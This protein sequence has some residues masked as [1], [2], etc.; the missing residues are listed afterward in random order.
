VVRCFIA[1]DS[2]EIEQFL[3]QITQLERQGFNN[4]IN[5]RSDLSSA[6]FLQTVLKP[7]ARSSPCKFLQSSAVEASKRNLRDYFVLTCS[8]AQFGPV[9]YVTEST[10][11][12]RHDKCVEHSI[13][14]TASYI[15]FICKPRHA[16]KD[17][18]HILKA[19]CLGG[20]LLR[21]TIKFHAGVERTREQRHVKQQPQV[22]GKGGGVEVVNKNGDEAA[23]WGMPC[24]TGTPRKTT[25]TTT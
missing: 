7:P 12:T 18:I 24:G 6:K 17:Y 16:F 21:T 10:F 4:N 19:I 15:E 3:Y 13:Q 9:K 25:R 11:R 1:A 8:N 2:G 20:F 14:P 5:Q 22:A 23:A